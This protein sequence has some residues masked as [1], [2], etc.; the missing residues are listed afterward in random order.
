LR[1]DLAPTNVGID[2]PAFFRALGEASNGDAGQVVRKAALPW[3]YVG[4]IRR[5]LP[6]RRNPAA[7]LKACRAFRLNPLSFLEDET[8]QMK[9]AQ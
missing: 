5:R 1:A 7:F 4:V 6:F 9:G 2:W 3:Q 8:L